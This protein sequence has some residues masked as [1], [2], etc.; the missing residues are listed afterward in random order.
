MPGKRGSIEDRFWSKVSRGPGCWVWTGSTIRGYGQLSTTR[1]AGPTLAHRFSWQI[2]NGP[3]P[4]AMQVLHRCDNPPCVNP[5]HLFLGDPKINSDDKI[6]K[7]RYRCGQKLTDEQVA[8]VRR[9]RAQGVSCIDL[10][11]RFGVSRSLVTLIASGKHRGAC[12]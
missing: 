3:I 2:H 11:L 6:A 8:S 10:S 4:D 1:S 12:A 5:D 9:L 7:G